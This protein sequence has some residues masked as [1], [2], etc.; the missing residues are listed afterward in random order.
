[1]GKEER[2]EAR[3]L[4]SVRNMAT[5]AVLQTVL[6][7][8]AFVDRTIFIRCLS[9]EYLGLNSLFSNILNV[10]SMAELGMSSAIAFALYKPIAEKN[11]DLIKS[12]MVFFKKAYQVIGTVILVI[13]IFLSPFVDR[14]LSNEQEIEHV[15]VYFLI[16]LFGVG[17][18]YFYSYKQI[19]IEA[20]QKK[21]INQVVICLGSILR[22][23][24]QLAAVSI[25]RDYGVYI[26]I[27]LVF[28]VG[29]N[30][31]LAIWAN[32]LYPFLKERNVKKLEQKEKKDITR[33]IKAL[34]LHKFGEVAI[35]SIDSLLISAL[36][37]LRTLGLYANYQIITNALR[38]AMR[39]F[40]SSMGASIGNMC[41]TEDRKQIYTSF[42]SLDFANYFISSVITVLMFSLIQSVMVLWL[43]P[44][45]TLKSSTVLLISLVF[46]IESNRYMVLNFHDACGLFWA[47]KYKRILE[48][49]IN[50]IVSYILGRK[51]GIDGIFIGTVVCNLVGFVIEVNVV[52]KNI[53]M[54]SPIRFLFKYFVRTVTTTLIAVFIYFVC[55]LYKGSAIVSMLYSIVASIILVALIYYLLYHRNKDFLLVKK[56]LKAIMGSFRKRIGRAEKG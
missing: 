20:D 2:N 34:S 21:Y 23:L 25:T 54:I 47:D 14:F 41:A 29:K 43:G 1:M 32:K 38:S 50:L 37:D 36:V 12:Y 8:L 11:Y 44:A 24:V 35:G 6:G 7:I 4:N 31:I 39:V 15:P 13:G 10:L 28:N 48:A 18:T 53:F 9:L 17:L 26:F 30:V 5:S 51:M 55:S 3:V 22:I 40:Y 19:L 27:Y 45:F 52:F 16:Y 46:F 56:S 42:V 33:N 49:V